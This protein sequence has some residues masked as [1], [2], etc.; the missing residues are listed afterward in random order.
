MRKITLSLLAISFFML[1]FCSCALTQP[2]PPVTEFEACAKVQTGDE[3][4]DVVISSTPDSC[5]NIKVRKPEVLNS[6]R[7]TYT[8]DTLYIEY[9]KLR[10]NATSDYLRKEAFFDV[11]YRALKFDKT[12]PLEIKESDSKHTKYKVKSE[13]GDIELL[14]DTK[15]GEIKEI[16]PS[17]AHV[18]IEFQEQKE[19]RSSD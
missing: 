12:K 5:I 2:S 18:K 7:Y 6:L 9:Q 16:T 10:C 15:S 19:T 1:T 8:K 17:Y 11:I 3:S 13:Y 14:C 4:Y